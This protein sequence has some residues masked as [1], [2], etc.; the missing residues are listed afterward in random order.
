[1]STSRRLCEC[2]P[3]PIP[4]EEHENLCPACGRL[5]GMDPDEYIATLDNGREW[6]QAENE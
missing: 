2:D 5:I 6:P 1:M 4:D 3:Q